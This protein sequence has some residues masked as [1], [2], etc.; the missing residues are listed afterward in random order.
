[1]TLN[2]SIET[3]INNTLQEQ[4]YPTEAT[5][6]KTYEDGHVDINTI[7]G[8]LKHIKSINPHEIG[9]TTILIFLNNS[10]DERRVI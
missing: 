9:D 3:I 7:Y 4:P 6:T 10:Y 1:M 5:I 2:E 8:E